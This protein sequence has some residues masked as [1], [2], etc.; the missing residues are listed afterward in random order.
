MQT[1]LIVQKKQKTTLALH[2]VFICLAY[3]P[4]E[5]RRT[6]SA[7]ECAQ[8]LTAL[9]YFSKLCHAMW[10]DMVRNE[11]VFPDRLIS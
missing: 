6:I 3:P 8:M 4:V 5:R 11:R 10:R 1:K 2:S 7:K 9:A